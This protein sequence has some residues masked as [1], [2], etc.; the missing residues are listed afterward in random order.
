MKLKFRIE[1][2]VSTGIVRVI[3]GESVTVGDTDLM[4]LIGGV[5]KELGE[6]EEYSD[7][8]SNLKITCRVIKEGKK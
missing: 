1:G 8:T 3:K 7:F 2:K 4:T 6:K 5:V